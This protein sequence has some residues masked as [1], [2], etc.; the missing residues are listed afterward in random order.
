MARFDWHEYKE[1]RNYSSHVDKLKIAVDFIRSYY[2]I[3]GTRDI[4]DMLAEDDIGQMML[5]KREIIDVEGFEN[6]IFHS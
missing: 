6:F 5:A 1:F 4:Y 2:K 3:T